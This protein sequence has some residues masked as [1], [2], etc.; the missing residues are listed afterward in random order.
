M[1]KKELLILIVEDNVAHIELISR[2]LEDSDLKVKLHV[3]ENV[4]DAHDFIK[5]NAPS[6]VITDLNLPDG[7]GTEL[8]SING[9]DIKYPVMLMTSFG[10][11][12]IAV[13]AIKLGA[14]DYFV[15]TPEI[16]IGIDKLI[17]RVLREWK[18]IE[19]R[20][21]AQHELLQKE[22][23][24]REVLNSI[25]DAVITIDETSTILTFNSIAEKLFNYSADEIIGTSL[26]QLIPES[27]QSKHEQGIKSYAQTA[28]AKVI[29]MEGGIELEAM[30]KDKTIFPIRLSIGE[31]P[32]SKDGLRRF[33]GIC[34]D[35]TKLKQQEEYLSR[36]QKM[37]AMGKLTGGIAHDY[38]NMLGVVLGYAEL[39]ESM[40]DDEPELKKYVNEIMRAGERGANLT[41]KL[42]SFSR[43]RTSDLNVLSLNDIL[44]DQRDMLEKTLTARIKLV[45]D[46]TDEI[47]MVNIDNSEF[48]D[49]IINMSINAMYAIEG[50]GSLIFKTRIETLSQNDAEVLQVEA[51]DY[52]VLSIS[53]TGKGIDATVKEKI[54]EPFFTTKGELG[55]GLGLS[56]VYGFVRRC[57][58]A[59]K[60]F[61]KVGTGTCLTLYFPRYIENK[62]STNSLD[63]DTSVVNNLSGTEKILVVDDEFSLR[64]LTSK[65]L[66]QSGYKV[67]CVESGK[68][69]LE[70]LE[71]EP[72]DLIFSDVIMPEMDGFQLAEKVKVKYPSIKIQLTSGFSDGRHEGIKDQTLHKNLLN[73]PFE[74][75]SLLKKIRDLLD[76]V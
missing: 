63:E 4:S 14:L 22:S 65:I 72:F 23:E 55:T 40:L 31:L 60:V 41:K 61:T 16:F 19:A 11:E 46:L 18:N 44:K 38:N 73:K 75:K 28:I 58:G 34:Q 48:E 70:L 24:Q 53:D 17:K 54:F 5:T 9:N 56:Q 13:E 67:I 76:A 8:I 30:R 50:N 32:A 25:M 37:E 3:C 39:L 45:F 66:E 20:Q 7:K 29:G 15:K 51:T 71:K 68:Q 27:Y 42:L 35:L 33:I 10:D 1:I 57:C 12:S 47:C 49:A 36:S 26:L 2:S 52:I 74:T 59:I 43:Q 62:T 64:T 6:L 21:K 69:A